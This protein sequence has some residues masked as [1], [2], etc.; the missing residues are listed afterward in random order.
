MT[1]DIPRLDMDRL[2]ECAQMIQFVDDFSE[3]SRT[4]F[5]AKYAQEM[6]H[7]L[8]EYLRKVGYWEDG[9]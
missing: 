7:I 3:P 1:K 8:R 6:L 4:R 9:E 2:N 5:R